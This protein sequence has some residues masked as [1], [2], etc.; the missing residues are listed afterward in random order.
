MYDEKHHSLDGVEETE[1]PLHHLRCNVVTNDK[2]A[3]GPCDPKDR[4]EDKGGVEKGAA[5]RIK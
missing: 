3:E 4:Q 1:E 5:A 2:E